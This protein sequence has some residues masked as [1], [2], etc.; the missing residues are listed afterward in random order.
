MT[1]RDGVGFLHWCLPI[2]GLRWAGYRRV[3]RQVCKR[4][5]RRLAALR[6]ADLAAYRAYIEGHNEEW[7]EV[8][9]A[10][11]IPI[12]RFFRD[13]AVFDL[14]ADRV[15]PKIA[16]RK[17]AAG[18][19]IR[20]WSLGCA[21]GEEPY[22]LNIL[23]KLGPGRRFPGMA[24][25]ILASDAAPH[26]LARA[27]RGCYGAGSL[28]EVPASWR[29]E[30]FERQ[31]PLYCVKA[32][33]R[34][35]IAFVHADASRT[36]PEGP[37]DLLMCRNVVFTYFDAARQADMLA[38]LRAVMAPGGYLVVGRKEELPVGREEFEALD[39]GPVYRLP[40]R[41]GAAGPDD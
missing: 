41:G 9:A 19:A 25:D 18:G 27:R 14:L 10:C 32:P 17:Q 2:L 6:L 35:G 1:E 38:R 39:G 3:H 8:E 15:L 37:F 34:S 13:R 5:A 33:F 36:L 31:G 12:S 21:S 26:L 20:C 28:K 40:C 24:L 30:A 7:A 29:D 16:R 4:L 23:W 11:L 22:S